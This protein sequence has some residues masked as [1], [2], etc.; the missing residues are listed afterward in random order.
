MYK[1]IQF[2]DNNYIGAAIL[3]FRESY[4]ISQRKLCKGL[5]S[6]TTL[7][8]IEAGERD[9]DA[10]ILE[11]LLERLGRMPYHFELIVTDFDYEV[12]L[13][14]K[15]IDKLIEE[16]S[17]DEAYILIKKYAQLTDGKGTPHKQFVLVCKSKLNELKGGKC[18]T[19]IDILIEAISCTVPDF[20]TND[21]SNH[22][23]STME[24]NIIIDII[25]KMIVTNKTEQVYQILD[26]II[27]YLNRYEQ[28]EQN[29]RRFPKVAVLA[30]SFFMNHNDL[31]KAL[32]ICNRGIE[33]QKTTTKL[34]YIGD[35]LYNKAKI[36]EKIL[37]R[38]GKKDQA[39]RKECLKLF[40][41]AYYLFDFF[42]D[43]DKGEKIKAHVREEY[44]WED[45]D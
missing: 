30:S 5:C 15:E 4:N 12:Y 23:L 34:N 31:D 39:A 8:R 28:M 16:E 27:Y 42:G 3:Y 32:K 37:K 6:I 18:E 35:L 19:T 1:D 20:N 9:V 2:E 43:S 33:K 26:Q 25:D 44:Q 45:I 36:L 29:S 14:R 17:I 10:L 7:S 22:F 21:I 24:F 40:L 41:E 38:S 11:N 13:I